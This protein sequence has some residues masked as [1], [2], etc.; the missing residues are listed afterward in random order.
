MAELGEQILDLQIQMH[1]LCDERNLI[2]ARLLEQVPSRELAR[3]VGISQARLVALAM[4]HR[5]G[6][7][8]RRRL[9]QGDS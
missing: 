6:A 1:E 4:K 5:R 9:A 2:I 3:R 8:E 7:G